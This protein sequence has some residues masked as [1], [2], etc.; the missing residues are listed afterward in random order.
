MRKSIGFLTTVFLVLLLACPSNA[1]KIY[2]LGTSNASG[3]Y[4]DNTI[5]GR[6]STNVKGALDELDAAIDTV[7]GLI[8]SANTTGINWAA[9]EVTADTTG[10]DANHVIWEV[11]GETVKMTGAS[12][13]AWIKAETAT[14]YQPLESTL[15]DIADGTI[16][17]DLVNTAHPWADNEVSDTITVGASGSVN[18]AAIPSGITRDSEWDTLAKINSVIGVTLLADTDIYTAIHN[19]MSAYQAADADLTDL[20]DG[21]LTGS[22]VGDG[23]DDD[24][25]SFDDADNLWTATKIGPAL[26]ELNDSINEGACNG[27]GAKV[28]WSQITGVPAGFADGTDDGE[29]GGGLASTDIDTESELEAIMS[30]INLIVS[31]EIDSTAELNALLGVTISTSGHTHDYQASSALLSGIA[32]TTPSAGYL[33]YTGAAYEWAEPTVPTASSL[34]V[35]DIL[36]AIGIASEATHLGTFTGSTIAD[37][38]TV[39]AALQALETAVEGVEVGATDADLVAIA[40]IEDSGGLY[41]TGENTWAVRSIAVSGDGL[42]VTNPKGLAGNPTLALDVTPSSGSATL[43]QAEDALQVKYA[44]NLTEGA[45]GLDTIQGIKTTST[46]QFARIGVGQAA[47]GTNPISSSGFSVDADGDVTAKSFTSPKVSGEAGHVWA[48]E[49]NSTDTSH[50][51]WMGPASIAASWD[52]Q[53]SNDQPSAGQVMAFGAVSNSIS[54]QTWITPLTASSSWTGGDLAGTGLA[55]TIATGA[56]GADELA[57]TAVTAGSY[58][59]ANITVDADGRIT[60]AANGTAGEGGVSITD[61]SDGCLAITTANGTALLNDLALTYNTSTNVLTAGGFA[62]TR[63]A[64]AQYIKLYEGN[65]E[66]GDNYIEFLAQAMAA[67]MSYTLPNA[68]PATD[69]LVLNCTSAGVMSWASGGAGAGIASVLE[70]TS[71]ELGGNLLMNTHAITGANA[72]SY[73]ALGAD[74]ADSGA[75]RLSNNTALAFEQSTPGTDIFIALDGSDIL[76]VGQNCADIRLGTSG[77]GNVT[78]TGDL[79]VS[80]N[81]ITFGNAETISNATNGDLDFTAT[82]HDFHLD[83]EAYLR[84]TTAN[85]GA[86]TISQV[87]DGADGITVGDSDDLITAGAGGDVH[88]ALNVNASDGTYS[89]DTIIRTVDASAGSTAFGQ[90]YH[91]DT[92]GELIDADADVSTSGSIPC[93]GLAITTGTGASKTILLRGIITETDWNWTVG[94]VIYVSADPATTCGL[95]QTAPSTA[96]HTVQ[97][98]GIALSADTISFNPSLDYILLK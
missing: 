15:T 53:F 70:D 82:N 13:E 58:T 36:T 1:G 87:S 56:V 24:N 38:S 20:A 39:K 50:V 61:A 7:N 60:S 52:Y 74:P 84:I 81:D 67:N 30:G 77:T 51:G 62:T 83:A 63:T 34:H 64:S 10:L 92:D 42:D 33:H 19:T 89:G 6:T 91:V 5:S 16:A 79:T 59:N 45:S 97:A 26:E 41:R 40:A 35:D 43:E 29:G 11:G 12:L 17:E 18:D 9:M 57:A 94:G 73:I 78:V 71:P 86:S 21:S 80:G 69:G 85:G 47:D 98:V 55:A 22:K 88:V 96:G 46:P 54:A 8:I 90:A 66:P 23:I 72:A 95:T 68:Y 76:Q 48:Y 32:G 2:P 31:T 27:T 3:I 37:S 65:G 44:D 75:I 49:A 25:V 4:Y 93:I 28:H 14:T